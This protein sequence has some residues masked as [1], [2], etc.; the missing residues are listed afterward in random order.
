MITRKYKL[1]A[2][3]NTVELEFDN[4]ELL[5]RAHDDEFGFDEDGIP[6]LDVEEDVLLARLLQQEYDILASV[7][8][9]AP[10]PVN[11]VAAK[12]ED[13]P[14]EKQIEWAQNLGMKNPE[15]RTKKEVWAFIQK[16]KDD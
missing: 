11:T 9:I 7:K 4:D 10:V 12:P 6:V 1:A 5:S 13:R 16:H 14:S 3:F 2:N 8:V 15:L